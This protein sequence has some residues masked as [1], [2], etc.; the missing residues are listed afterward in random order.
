MKTAIVGSGAMGQLFGARMLLAGVEVVL[1]DTNPRTLHALN[2]KGITLHTDIGVEHTPASAARAD[3]LTGTFDLFV[4]F[5]K[6]FHTQAAVDSIRHLIG[7]DSYGLTLQNGL[8]NAEILEQA[9]G[10]ERTLLGIT[11]FPADMD[12][13]GTLSSDSHGTVRLGSLSGSPRLEEIADLLDKAGL[14]ASV[15]DDIRAPIWEKVAF[16]AAL[17]TLSAVTGLTVGQIGAEDHARRIVAAVL[18]EASVVA[19]S[20]GINLS[21]EHVEEAVGNAFAHHGDHRTSMLLDREAG[22]PTEVES[23]GGAIVRLGGGN[24]VPTPVLGTLCDLV[25]ALSAAE[26]QR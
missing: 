3:E 1:L 18:D 5:T 10:P 21:R 23:I 17:N 19:H 26:V 15:V 11:D 24:G 25:R 14:H 20:Q 8:G 4:V 9:F 22:R 13:P 6:G 2:A 12:E 16:N 7:P